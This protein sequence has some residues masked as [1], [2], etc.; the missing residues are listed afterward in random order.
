MKTRQFA[1]YRSGRRG[2]RLVSR[3][4][5]ARRPHP[6]AYDAEAGRRT[7]WLAHFYL[8]HGT[9]TDSAEAPFIG[10]DLGDEFD[11][12]L[13]LAPGKVIVLEPVIWEDGHWGFRAEDIVAVTDT[14]S[15]IALAPRPGT[16]YE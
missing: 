9:G 8:A 10:T 4:A 2:G 6:R 3:G 16:D 12:T 15:D 14:G 13:V 1:R 11:E 7:P 5:T